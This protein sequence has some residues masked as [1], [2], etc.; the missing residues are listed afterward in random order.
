MQL[1]LAAIALVML[2]TVVPLAMTGDGHARWEALSRSFAAGRVQEMRYSYIG[3]LFAA[4]FLL[5]RSAET[6]LW[7]GTRFNVMLL[8]GGAA[9][10]WWLL[11]GLVP[12][13]TRAAFI[14]LLVAGGMMPFHVRDFYGE[15]FTAVLV[16]VGLAIAIG[17]EQ[18][19][20]WLAVVLGAAN[21]P[22]SAPALALVAVWRAVRSRRFDGLVAFAGVALLIVVENW[23]VRGSPF[24]GGYATDHGHRTVMPF[25]GRAG[26][27]YP[28]VFGVASL[29]L[30]FGKGVLFFAPGLV[31]VPY[32][33]R[34]A[35]PA[36]AATL[37]AWG[38]FLVGLVLVFAKWW[39]WYGGWYWG[40]R[41]LLFAAFPAAL[42]L[43]IVVT[44][45][46]RLLVAALLAAW[47]LWVGVSG[48]VFGMHGLEVCMANDYALE[49]LC[50]YAP[51]FSPLFRPLVIRMGLDLSQRAWILVAVASA[52]AL[53]LPQLWSSNGHVRLKGDTAT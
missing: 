12:P 40:P 2:F 11:R 16:A 17:K 37:E 19:A 4:P 8:A 31:T 34:H 14:L 5:F 47:T 38:I 28:M 43:A 15:V 25:S 39:S 35:S 3:P 52:A 53:T 42:A 33:R 9:A 20:G 23:I 13:P 1:A 41:F 22:A 18:R 49:H 36:V 30:S 21:T 50:W 27:S 48:A 51:E 10:C 32:A 7:W 24:N 29:L 26:F 6:E 45:G 46:K 44:S